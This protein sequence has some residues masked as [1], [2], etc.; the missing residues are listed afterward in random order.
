VNGD[1]GARLRTDTHALH[2]QAEHRPFMQALLR[3]RLSTHAYCLLL[4]NLHPIYIA[5][6]S[7]LLAHAAHPMLA[8][9]FNPALHRARAIE[10]DLQT[11]H[12]PDW[13]SSLP[14]LASCKS[15]TE[16][17]DLL[18]HTCPHALA[19]HAYVRFLGDLS[20]GQLLKRIVR[21]GLQL[22]P[23]GGGTHFYDFGDT[24]Q[25]ALLTR[26]FRTGLLGIPADKTL[27]DE[28]VAEARHA[29]GLHLDLFDQLAAAS[30]PQVFN[31]P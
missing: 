2:V 16:R 9:I 28:I 31:E 15:Y 3:A 1:L 25:T 5:L 19:A 18:R 12:G 27:I 26:A 4:R 11:L 29:Y 20:G 30:T 14:R 22:A 23:E 6:E 24:A 10:R 17:L 21:D 8:P 7:A 13:A